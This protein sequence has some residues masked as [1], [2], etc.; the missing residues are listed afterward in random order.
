MVTEDFKVADLTSKV[1]DK[2]DLADVCLDLDLTIVTISFLISGTGT[3]LL[4]LTTLGL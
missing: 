3:T 1:L 2:V 4:A